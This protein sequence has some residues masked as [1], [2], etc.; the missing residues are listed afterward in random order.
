MGEGRAYI[1]VADGDGQFMTAPFD[2]VK[3]R[4]ISSNGF[5]LLV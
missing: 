5:S 3:L 1:S 2:T 4:D